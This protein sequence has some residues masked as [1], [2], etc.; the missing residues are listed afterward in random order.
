MTKTS[1][2]I[3]LPPITQIQLGLSNIAITAAGSSSA[4]ATVCDNYND[5]FVMTATGT[6][7]IRMNS[8]TPLLSHIFVVNT[9]GSNGLVYPNTGGAINGGS[10]DA[11]VT[12]G[13]NKSAMLLRVTT[14]VWMSILS[15]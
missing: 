15:A 8:G 6:D 2:L 12:V 5:V 11:G 4:N 1:E 10:T 13:A 3:G 14:N 9:S 7:G